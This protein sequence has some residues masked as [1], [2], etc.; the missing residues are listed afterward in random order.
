MAGPLATNSAITTAVA[1]SGN[2]SLHLVVNPGSQQLTTFYQD[3]LPVNT[4]HGL[5]AELL[6]FGGQP[7][8]E[9]QCAAEFHLSDNDDSAHDSVYARREQQRAK[10]LPPYPLLWLSEVQPWNVTGARDNLGEAEPWIEIFN[11]GSNAISNE[12]VLSLGQLTRILRGG[13]FPGG[14]GVDAERVSTD[15]GR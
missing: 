3:M 6:V 9:L 2:A 10:A 12:R 13:R 14:G 5:Y 8:I 15:L 11:S 1:H 4:Q 7:R